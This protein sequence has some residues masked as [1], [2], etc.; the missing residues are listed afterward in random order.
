MIHDSITIL[1]SFQQVHVNT[2]TDKLTTQY[3][4]LVC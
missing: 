4:Y 3:K 2:A 1:F